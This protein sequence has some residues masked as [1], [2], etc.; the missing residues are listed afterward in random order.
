MTVDKI[1]SPP[2]SIA[3]LLTQP[4]CQT[5]KCKRIHRNYKGFSD[6]R[7]EPMP[8]RTWN[9]AT[10]STAF[11][12]SLLLFLAELIIGKKITNPIA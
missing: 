4:S 12:V 7:A 3:K 1:V 8:S 2:I 9:D 6:I 5:Q 10:N 11:F